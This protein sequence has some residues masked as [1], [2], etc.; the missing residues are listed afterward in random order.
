MAQELYYTS[1]RKGL[2]PGTRGFCTVAHTQGMQPGTVRLLERLSAYKTVFGDHRGESVMNP[3]SVSHHRTVVRHET[4]S[5]MS[6]VGP[7]GRDHTNRDNK[8]AHHILLS[9]QERAPGGP[10][11]LAQ[12][13][14]FAEEWLGEPRFI[15][16][17]LELPV[18]DIQPGVAETWGRVTGDPGWAGVLSNSFETNPNRPAYLVFEPGMDMLTLLAEAVATLTTAKRWLVTFNTYFTQLPVGMT[19]SW[20]CCL[21]DFPRLRD[22][23]YLSGVLVIDFRKKLGEPPPSHAVKVARGEAEAKAPRRRHPGERR[24]EAADTGFVAMRNRFRQTLNI[25][26]G[27]SKERKNS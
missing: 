12:Q 17:P 16:E 26:P 23:R 18:G 27:P 13:G 8:L 10:A 14:V 15:P 3:V 22:P 25:R 4:V 24:I 2:K 11:W 9:K 20:R 6:R 1:A 5:I 7:A 19:C 21:P